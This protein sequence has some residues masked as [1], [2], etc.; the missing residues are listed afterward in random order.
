MRVS[1]TNISGID[2]NKETGK[3]SSAAPV[4]EGKGRKTPRVSKETIESTDK[5]QVSD[6]AKDSATAKAVALAAP[7][8]NEEKVNRIKDSIKS[9]TYKVD[10]DKIADR[11]VD[12]HLSTII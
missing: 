4:S 2:Q 8:I 9:G 12:D 6:R 5:V 7:D 3:A 1:N 11:L 10:T